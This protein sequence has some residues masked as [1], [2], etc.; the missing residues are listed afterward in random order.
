MRDAIE[1][2][3]KKV[4]YEYKTSKGMMKETWEKMKG[5]STEE[6]VQ[7]WE[8]AGWIVANMEPRDGIVQESMDR[9]EKEVERERRRKSRERRAVSERKE[10]E[11]AAE[12]NRVF[13]EGNWPSRGGQAHRSA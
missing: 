5:M 7:V 4:Y 13:G 10:R 12:R 11:E 6:T 1:V 2:L 8:R 9:D 3:V